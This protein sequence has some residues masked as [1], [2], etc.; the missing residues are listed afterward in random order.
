MLV[1]SAPPLSPKHESL[2]AWPAHTMTEVSTPS[3]DQLVRQL[4]SVANGTSTHRRSSGKCEGSIRPQPLTTA[5]LLG[6]GGPQ[7][8][9]DTKSMGCAPVASTV[10]VSVSTA[11]SCDSVAGS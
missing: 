7:S 10:S 3:A 1:T 8:W 5:V 9:L 11:A 6:D 4:E 2:P